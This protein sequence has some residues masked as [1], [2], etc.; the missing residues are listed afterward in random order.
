[1]PYDPGVAYRGDQYLFQGI[2][3]L[4]QSLAGGITEGIDKTEELRKK[5]ALNDTVM[6]HALSTGRITQDD[7]NKY[8]EAGFNKKVGIANGV[9]SN[10]HDDWQR[11]QFAA[12]ER[13]KQLQRDLQ[14]RIAQ[15]AHSGETYNPADL[16]GKGWG[17]GEPFAEANKAGGT[18]V[19]TSKGAWTFRP[20][21]G[22]EG[23]DAPK[24][25]P[26]TSPTT[27]K[28]V[29]NMGM[30]DKTG[31]IVNFPSG[32][33][34]TSG[35]QLDP[36][37]NFYFDSKGN[38]HELS[39]ATRRTM[40][41][42]KAAQAAQAAG[43]TTMQTPYPIYN[44]ARWLTGG[45]GWSGQIPVPTPTPGGAT[46]LPAPVA[47]AAAAAPAYV[48]PTAAPTS[49]AALAPNEAVR[50]TKDGRRA[51]FDTTTKQFLRYAD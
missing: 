34:G 30:V 2:S 38:P 23:I 21:P 29:P 28:P 11:Q 1:M 42:Q 22:D 44:P 6:Q 8:I 46:P 14:L 15:M 27:G 50:V 12:E 7:Y 49:P 39:K 26:V 35:V 32:T 9:M 41:Q 43:N 19:Q 16:P 25:L 4:G 20:Y 13:D 18:L 36:T 17:P 37:E 3:G 48:A 51:I 40:Q 24:I 45:G 31:A 47:A 10:I 33:A 5:A